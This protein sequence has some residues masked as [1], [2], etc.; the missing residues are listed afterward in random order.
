MESATADSKKQER[1][2]NR[3]GALAAPKV[4]VSQ[5]F[6]LGW[7]ICLLYLSGEQA[8]WKQ[9]AEPPDRLPSPSFF[10]E[11][12]HSL[13]RLGQVR[14]TVHHLSSSLS[15]EN[16]G[17]SAFSTVSTKIEVLFPDPTQTGGNDPRVNLSQAHLALT[18]VLS[19]TDPRL[20][21]AYHLGC[22]LAAVC[23]APHDLASL[24][25][26]FQRDHIA[27]VGEALADLTSLF[28]DHSCRAVRLS[29]AEWRRWVEVP[30]LSV[31]EVGENGS[32]PPTGLKQAKARAVRKTRGLDWSLD[33]E[34]VQRS[35]VRQG[36]VWRALLSGE[37]PGTAMLELQDYF[38]T[39][40]RALK[41]AFKLLGGMKIPLAAVLLLLVLGCALLVSDAG[42]AAKVGGLVAI[43]SSAGLT[44]KGFLGG[45]G[46]VVEQI[47]KPVWGAA[48]DEVI[49]GAITL[50]PTGAQEAS[51]D[52]SEAAPASG[53]QPEALVA[54]ADEK[55]ASAA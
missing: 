43:A 16:G 41:K 5:T 21:K 24:Q 18:Q 55:Q 13:I 9:P 27:Q 7:N 25:A 53:P 47:Q 10:S 11:P 44:W 35:L 29:C 12:E 19:E 45:L 4:P 39:G 33:G 38:T 17:G 22:D 3:A 52:A 2:E 42:A 20:A 8:K 31:A 1:S 48:L 30:E 6:S 50:L 26:E 32:G 23:N 36:D 40:A 15:G 49:A 34:E 37:K 14:S 54:G 51:I 28:P 46:P